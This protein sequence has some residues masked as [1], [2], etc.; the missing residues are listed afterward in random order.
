VGDVTSSGEPAHPTNINRA[1]TATIRCL[2]A[3]VWRQK[4]K[5]T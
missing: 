3:R 5:P 4:L 1:T 2:M